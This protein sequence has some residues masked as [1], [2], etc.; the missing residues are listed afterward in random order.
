MKLNLTA[1]V[2]PNLKKAVELGFNDNARL[3]ND[4]T[5]AALHTDPAFN[6]LF[7]KMKP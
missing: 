7:Q 5:F 6:D 3:Q 2:L 4:P 1:Y